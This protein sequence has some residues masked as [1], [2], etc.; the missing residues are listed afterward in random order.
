M[1]YKQLL[2]HASE[3]LW[4]V[5]CLSIFINDDRHDLTKKTSIFLAIL[6]DGWHNLFI[7]NA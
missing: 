1:F 2:N 5:L 6:S 4:N 3:V 7:D